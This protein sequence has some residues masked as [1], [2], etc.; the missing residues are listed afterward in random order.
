M[1]ENETAIA[2]LQVVALVLPAV[3]IYLQILSSRSELSD[4]DDGEAANYH[5]IRLSFVY[6]LGSG[7]I[8]IG[9]IL[10]FP[11]WITVGDVFTGIAL[12][13]LALALVTFALPVVFSRVGLSDSRSILWPY[14]N[15]LHRLYD[16]VSKPE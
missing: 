10:V 7:V 4:M 12:V 13:L 14:Q 15:M 11:A 5:S 16:F 3:A 8:L 6:L 9:A 1:A 2:L